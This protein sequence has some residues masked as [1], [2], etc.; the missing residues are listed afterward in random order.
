[1]SK[2][3]AV[4]SEPKITIEFVEGDLRLAGWDNDEILVK[5][6]EDTIS[7]QQSGDDVTISCQDDL[8][9]N[10]PRNSKVHVQTVNG[11]MSVRGLPGIFEADVVNGDIAIR[12]AGTVTLNAVE[13]DF[14]LRGAKGDVHVKSIGGDA[15]LRDVNG[16]LT[17]DSVSDDLAIRGVG[18]NLKVDVDADVV[19]HALIDALLGAV[20]LNDI[21]VHFPDHD[22][23]YQ[24]VSSLTLLADTFSL[25]QER[26]WRV[27]NIDI[28]VIA[29][30]PSIN[31]HRNAMRAA[32][33]S[34][35]RI[36]PEDI[37]IKATTMEGLGFTS[38]KQGIAA[39]AVALLTKEKVS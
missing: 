25:V 8:A 33:S 30:E 1:M 9:I 6:D 21:G 31:T 10:L 15:S 11:D 28:V 20:G 26:G 19:V 24:G 4:G 17:L 38:G 39:Y 3:L 29:E 27:G 16:N 23:R 36:S 13:S 12:D 7:L 32:L 22:P 37:N 2:R 35:L 14:N 34:V 5:A 18:G